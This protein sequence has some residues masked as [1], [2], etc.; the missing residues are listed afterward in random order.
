MLRPIILFCKGDCSL[1]PTRVL[2]VVGTRRASYYG[3]TQCSQIIRELSLLDDPPVI[4]SGL[5]FGIDTAAHRAALEVG[6]KTIAVIPTGPETVYPQQHRDLAVRIADEGALVTD[7]TRGCTAQVAH[8]VRRNRIIAGMSDATF[9][10]ESFAKGGGLITTDLANSYDHDVFALPGKTTDKGSEDCNNLIDR[11]IAHI[12]TSSTSITSLMEW[13]EGRR[14][15]TDVGPY[16]AF[17]P[18]SDK[19]TVLDILREESPRDFEDILAVSRM[20]FNALSAIL[21]E[22][23]M[24]G[25]VISVQGRKYGLRL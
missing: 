14:H 23:E 5:A 6:L 3:R 21:L 18:G 24:D 15:R 1:N 7:F 11:N 2:S 13:G 17:P 12:V 16:L 8:F 25:A 10:V 4:I 22:L 19:R 20:S 9:L